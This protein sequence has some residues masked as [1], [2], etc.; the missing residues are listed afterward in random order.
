VQIAGS[1]AQDKHVVLSEGVHTHEVLV[2]VNPGL[3]NVHT[4]ESAVH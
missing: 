3:H 4:L 1:V 2:K